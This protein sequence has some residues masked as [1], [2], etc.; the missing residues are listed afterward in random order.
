MPKL[1]L[2]QVTLPVLDEAAGYGLGA[3]IHAKGIAVFAREVIQGQPAL[4][5]RDAVAAACA[6]T[7]V[8]CVIVG[9]SRRAHLE[10]LA[11]ACG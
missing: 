4:A 1:S 2:L 7:D 8:A 5:P 9:T 10:E 11:H 6:R 3:Q